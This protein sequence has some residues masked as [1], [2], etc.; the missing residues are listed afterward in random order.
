MFLAKMGY[1]A[2]SRRFTD[3]FEREINGWLAEHPRIKI[4]EVCQSVGGGSFE[5]MSV[6]VSIWYEEET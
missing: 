2:S 3:R 5:P 1:L 4:V 6:A